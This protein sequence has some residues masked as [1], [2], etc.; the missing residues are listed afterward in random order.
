MG[1]SK[2]TGAGAG[3]ALRPFLVVL[4]VV[5]AL[6]G[7]AL[8]TIS[9]TGPAGAAISQ[10]D[11]DRGAGPTELAVISQT[12]LV[13]P[14]GTFNAWLDVG[15]VDLTGL[16]VVATIFRVLDSEAELEAEPLLTLNRVTLGPADTLADPARGLGIRIPVRDGQPI[17][18]I[19]R[20]RLP[21]AGVYPVII[22][23][24][25]EAGTVAAARTNLT[26]LP[27][28]DIATGEASSIAAL[29]EVSAAGE[30]TI[31]EATELLASHP[32][33]PVMVVLGAGTLPELEADPELTQ[34]LRAALGA[35]PVLAVV[36]P[37]LDPSALA[38]ISQGVL[39]GEAARSTADAVT[40]LGLTTTPASAVIETP[41]T[42]PG[43]VQLTELGVETA[44]DLSGRGDGSEGES[45]VLLSPAG[46]LRVVTPQEIA[47]ARPDGRPG[48]DTWLYQLLARLTLGRQA[49]TDTFLLRL[50]AS[51]SLASLDAFFAVAAGPGPFAPVPVEQVVPALASTEIAA[52]PR[53]AQDLAPV[54]ESLAG[55]LDQLATFSSFYVDGPDSPARY[56]S[57]VS[58]S[59][60]LGTPGPEQAEAIDE[61]DR[62]LTDALSV[63]SLPQNQS[64]T[65]A[66]RSVPIPL[67]I[68]NGSSGPRQV[69]LR[70][71]S[72]KFMVAE[73]G[74]EFTI[75]PGTS[76]IDIRVDA[77]S[78]GVSPLEVTV[79][80]P[81]GRRELASTRFQVR[82]TAIPGLGL[83]LSAAGL[84]LLAIW[85]YLSIRRRRSKP[86]RSAGDAERDGGGGEHP[87]GPGSGRG[88]DIERDSALSGGSV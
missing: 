46:Q 2:V 11:G 35:R 62:Q 68:T 42:R 8:P 5:A 69:L 49:G 65:L 82:S 6:G 38:A 50:P 57:L 80:T 44:I 7:L 53:P 30:L 71:R 28:E 67:T 45:G 19:D 72:D 85:W 27:A 34:A 3:R 73:D 51:A 26:R 41:L 13:A 21:D 39:Y 88:P 61:I 48:G 74:K 59:L 83:L 14:E 9:E 37:A 23:L 20:I 32:T 12:A 76:S 56:R 40:R 55:V 52:Q 22:E 77:R 66:A 24:R 79:L 75:E 81:D 87:D 36:D 70:F 17:D 15:A 60:G 84:V 29:L 1:P 4:T 33:V 47:S 58:Q 86:Q 63:M 64:V 54:A 43:A 25:S 31:T 78:L 16:E 10:Q 18:D